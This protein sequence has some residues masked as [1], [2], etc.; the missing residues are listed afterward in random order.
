MF[1][2]TFWCV[3]EHFSVRFSYGVY[4]V[5][6][7]IFSTDKITVKKCF[8]LK[9]PSPAGLTLMEKRKRDEREYRRFGLLKTYLASCTISV[10]GSYGGL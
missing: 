1:L 2:G 3:H 7:K 10:G 5:K 9:I 4:I 8:F 6:S